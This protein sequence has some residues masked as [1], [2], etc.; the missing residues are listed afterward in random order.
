MWR[1]SEGGG[2]QVVVRRLAEAVDPAEIDLHIITAR[3]DWDDLSEVQATTYSLG[4]GDWP[5]RP[6][7]KLRISV[8]MA[9]RLRQ[10]DPDVVQLHSGMVWLGYAA[11]V[12][13]PRT[14]FV[15]EVHDAPGS[16]RHGAWTDRIEG[17]CARWLGMRPLC[18]STEVAEALSARAG[19]R[20]E[21]IT[22]F[23]LGVDTERFAPLDPDQRHAWRSEHGIADDA[24]VAVAVG[25]PALPKRFDL[26]VDAAVAARQMVPE[27]QLLVI[28]PGSDETFAASLLAR[29]R[30]GAVDLWDFVPDL[31]TAMA[32]ADILLS[33][34]SYEGFGLTLAEGM[35]CGLP[36]VAMSVGGV[37]DVVADGTTGHLVP[38]GDLRGFTERLIAVAAD[39]DE[40]AA[41][42]GAGR[43][44]AETRFSIGAMAASFTAA[45]RAAAGSRRT[46]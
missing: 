24:V 36:V 29:D 6:W 32:S 18:H 35:A 8:A 16:G 4:F 12:L 7:N 34:S 43:E 31:A 10:I 26:A 20:R 39:P 19:I 46:L 44:R 25:R 3:P 38:T 42:G 15:L 14:P 2:V 17:W 45:Y 41:L 40:R 30:D 28:G 11:R 22:Q 33:T 13:A 21:H 27:L 37:P 23:P 5:G 1:L 9:R